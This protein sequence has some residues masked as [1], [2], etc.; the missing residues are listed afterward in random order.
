MKNSKTILFPLGIIFLLFGFQFCN[1]TEAIDKEVFP[2][3]VTLTA[4]SYNEFVESYNAFFTNLDE[5][6]RNLLNDFIQSKYLSKNTSGGSSSS[7]RTDKAECN[8][9]AGQT[10]CSSETWASDCCICCGVGQSAAC[11]SYWGVASCKCSGPTP[12]QSKVINTSG[13]DVPVNIYPNRFFGIFDF[14]E[15]NSINASQIR[16][17]LKK[18]LRK[19]LSIYK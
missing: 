13:T 4:A 17:E 7:G 11:G 3:K 1:K 15:S 12:K 10:T 5:N 19:A 6:K 8:C 9:S 18:V 14:A 16:E 2:D